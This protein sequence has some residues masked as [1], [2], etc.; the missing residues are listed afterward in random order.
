MD[1]TKQNHLNKLLIHYADEMDLD[2][3]IQ[4][5]KEGADINYQSPLNG[6]TAIHYAASFGYDEMINV[7]L[8]SEWKE[9]CKLLIRDSKNRLPSGCA[10]QGSGLGNI[11]ELSARL[12]KIEKKQGEAKGIAPRINRDEPLDDGPNI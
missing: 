11:M 8:S 1:E 10:A 4:S 9:S 3:V 7:L 5:L 6:M 2:G 12:M